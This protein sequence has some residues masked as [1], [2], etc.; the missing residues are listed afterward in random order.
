MSVLTP[1]KIII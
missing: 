1:K